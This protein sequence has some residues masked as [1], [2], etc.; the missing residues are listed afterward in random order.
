[1]RRTNWVPLA[2]VL[3][4]AFLCAAAA[5]AED[6]LDRALALFAEE[7]LSEARQALH[8]VLERDPGHP[9]ARLLLG[10]LD[11]RTGRV[12]DAIRTF[13][14]LL[15]DHPTMFEPYNNLAVLYAVQGRLDEAREILL[16]ALEHQPAAVVYEN[17]GDV[18]SDLAQRAYLRARSLDSGSGASSEE[19]ESD[20]PDAGSPRT[21]EC[22]R[23]GRFESLEAAAVAVEWL[24][25]REIGIA[26]VR[27]EEKR[28][29]TS[30]R[31]FLPPLESHERAAETVR[32]IQSAG[33]RDVAI[34]GDGG[35]KNGVSFGVYQDEK[36][37]R[38]R[39]SALEALGFAARSAP[40]DVERADE[41]VIEFSAPGAIAPEWKTRFPDHP[42]RTATC[43]EVSP[44][45]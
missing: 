16:A 6:A 7:R 21:G 11:A 32:D 10:I 9:Q 31:V 45:Q 26:A 2:S 36:N 22:A 20:T 37:M 14:A 18:Y 19:P 5:A 35:L 27:L 42:I 28:S 33:V 4:A 34:I 8:P 15:R 1:M 38:R 29:V 40:V 25:A 3:L 44:S 39:L 13:E 17:L 41:Y 23:A 12:S 30:W 43:S 24:R